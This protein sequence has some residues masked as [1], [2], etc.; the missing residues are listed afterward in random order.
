[1]STADRRI[2]ASQLYRLERATLA[3]NSII[4]LLAEY[5]PR[6]TA[7][8]AQGIS[9]AMAVHAQEMAEVL[10]ELEGEA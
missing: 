9:S 3:I 2:S 10:C 8:T 5:P 4:M 7:P 6:A 1:M